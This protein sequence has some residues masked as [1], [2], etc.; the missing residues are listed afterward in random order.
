[1]EDNSSG[2]LQVKGP[3]DNQLRIEEE[4]L[5]LK[6]R[7][8]G[9]SDTLRSSILTFVAGGQWDVAIREIHLYQK[10][11][12]TTDAYK[13]NT[14]RYFISAEQLIMAI[15]NLMITPNL[16]MLT[17]A[18]RQAVYERVIRH[19]EALKNVLEKLDTVEN[20]LKVKDL[21]ASVWVL[22]S[23]VFSLTLCGVT[24]ATVEAF[25]T[26][27]RPIAVLLYDIASSVLALIG[28]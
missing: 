14:R 25:R 17:M 15:K 18:K 3:D 20:D 24:L 2:A 10:Y 26:L 19:F 1:M 23:L 5:D 9:R 27:R 16:Y 28:M 21:R 7:I 22:Q 6:S 12:G 11:K 4:T 13:K 8:T